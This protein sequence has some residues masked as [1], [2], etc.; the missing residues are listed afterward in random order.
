MSEISDDVIRS[1]METL[2]KKVDLE[3]VTT[4][5]FMKLL[6]KKL[7]VSIK[8]L[9]I[10]KKF[11]KATITEILD[12][13]DEE[14]DDQS[15][16]AS[17]EEAESSSSSEE[18]EERPKPT[19]KKH[20][21]SSNGGSAPA[22]NP[23][24]KPKKLSP[25]LGSFLGADEMSRPQVVKRMW[26]YI[27]EHDLQNPSNKQEIDLDD[28]MQQVFGVERF[29]MFKMAKYISAHIEPFKPVTFDDEDD[30]AKKKK[31]KEA[32]KRK[33]KGG[34]DGPKKKRKNNMPPCRLSEDLAEVVGL[35]VST[36]PRVI[37]KLWEYIRANDLQ[38]PSD[39]REIIC[40]DT[41]KRIMGGE[42]KVTMFS[43]SKYLSPHFLEKVDRSNYV[44]TDAS[45]PEEDEEED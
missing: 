29:T 30:A 41:F 44:E 34:K 43:M 13:M 39:K 16:S 7:H 45:E 42:D 21:S 1:E 11:I 24:N 19:K 23:F 12:A 33:S 2:V 8:D 15:E 18:E 10:K 4:K 22:N 17:E 3:S 26:D 6:S 28:R 27:K 38:N 35:E 37:K 9:S 20:K 40:D 14:E 31:K 36:R 25:S 5:D 32:K